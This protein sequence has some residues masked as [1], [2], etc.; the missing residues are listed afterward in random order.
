M[1]DGVPNFALAI[2]YANA[3]WTLRSDLSSRYVC[4]FLNH[5][6]RRGRRPSATPSGP[7]GLEERPAVPLRSGYVQRALASLPVQGSAGPVDGA[8]ELPARPAPD[9]PRPASSED[10]HVRRADRSRP[11][12]PAWRSPHEPPGTVRLRRG[13]R[14][15]HR[16]GERHGRAAGAPAGR[17]RHRAWS[18]STATRD[19]LDR[20]GCG[21]PG[22]AP[23]PGRRVAR[24]WISADTA[25]IEPARPRDRRRPPARRPAG[26]QRR[27]RAG[28]TLR[29]GEP[30]GVRL[31]CCGSTCWRRWRSP[32]TCCRRCWPR[33]AATWSTSPACTG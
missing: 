25:A 15:G 6:R 22:G 7:P 23:G 9:A 32:T 24:R 26:Q 28:R 4:R 17:P 13:D 2:G 14:R 30:G 19:R 10:M 11:R 18:W 1:L 12:G 31:R 5:L 16:R 21:R 27:R 33:R 8:A 3:S 20:G 29:P